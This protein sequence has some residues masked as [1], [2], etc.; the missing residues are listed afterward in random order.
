MTIDTQELEDWLVAEATELRE[1][2]LH[3]EAHEALCV[4]KHI[5]V[6]ENE[7]IRRSGTDGVYQALADQP[8]Q[9]AGGNQVDPT[10]TRR[11]RNQPGT[12]GSNDL[13]DQEKV[14]EVKPVKY[15]R[16]DDKRVRPGERWWEKK[17]KHSDYVPPVRTSSGVRFGYH[18]GGADDVREDR[19]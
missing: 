5:R 6:T 3:R 12:H 8:A 1:L 16:K 10:G 15:M 13:E 11:W 9:D 14:Q 18:K 2:G 17:P 19:R 4:L 7:Q